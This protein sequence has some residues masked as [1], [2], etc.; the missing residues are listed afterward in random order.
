MFFF[1]ICET[2]A[3]INTRELLISKPIVIGLHPTDTS[4]FI[5]YL[6]MPFASSQ[7]KKEAL[8]TILPPV[9]DVFAIHLVYTRYKQ[10]DT[11]NQP[12]L[13]QRRLNVLKNI[14]PELFKQSGIQWR[15]FEQKTPNNLADAENC[16]HGFVVYLKNKPSKIE[17]D[18][19]LATIDRV[20]KSYKDTQVWIPEK[21]QYR[22]RKREEATG[23]YLPQN[24]EKRKNQVKYTTGS[25]W[26]R[27]KE[28]R[29]VRDSIPLK[30]I[31]GHFELT[32]FFDT[33]GLR[34]TDEFKILTR[35]KWLGSYAVLIDVTGSMTPYTAQVMLWMKHSKSCLENGRIVFFNDGNESPDILKRI[36]FTG[37]VHMVE[38]HHFDTA[39]ALM[40]TAMKMGDG[41]DIPENNIEALFLA[42]KKWP[43]VDSFIMIADNNAP[44]K[45]IVLIKQ[46]TKPVNIIL[47]G[48]LDRI[49]PH[50]IELAAKTNGR[51]YTINA[52][53]ANLNK[54]KFG[55]RIDIGKSV[56][57]YRKEGL[58]KLFDF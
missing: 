14:W 13:N 11:F 27:K 22:V 33:F 54:L 21:I 56:Y 3:Q 18:I 43:L 28:I 30:K 52:E 50:Y 47:C 49:H 8:K 37:G 5:V 42:Q 57:E 4:S 16:F 7:F 17:R 32:G 46:V 55:S 26:F 20:I 58:I 34:K 19:E 23:Y 45:D 1:S 41:G 35:K 31:A 6:P 36:G 39:Y 29:I 10:L 38:T 9:S 44:I 12:Q 15:V 2:R 51:I 40:Q 48:A 53:I 25:I 24:K